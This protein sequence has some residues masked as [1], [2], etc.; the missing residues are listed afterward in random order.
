VEHAAE[1]LDAC[2]HLAQHP[3]NPIAHGDIDLFHTVAIVKVPPEVSFGFGCENRDLCL[4][5]D[6]ERLNFREL[7]SGTSFGRAGSIVDIP[8]DVRNEEDFNVGEHYFELDQAEIK[9]LKALMP[10]M[11]TRDETVIRQDCLCYLM[12]RYDAHLA[13]AGNGD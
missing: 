6:L 12:E 4:L 11:L 9:T 7:P 8:F 13:D 1:Y 5:D 3:R 10:S 2:L